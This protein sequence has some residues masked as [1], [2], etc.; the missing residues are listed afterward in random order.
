M[1][2]NIVKNGPTY[3]SDEA[4]SSMN[5]NA[6]GSSYEE[7]IILDSCIENKLIVE[8]KSVNNQC[9][10]ES[11]IC[12]YM[13]INNIFVS[14]GEGLDESTARKDVFTNA[15]MLLKQTQPIL[16]QAIML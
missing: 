14:V 12:F 5:W 1:Y 7:E 10:K 9:S 11:A 8:L 13:L 3:F 16:R 2:G 4:A 15:F 6:A